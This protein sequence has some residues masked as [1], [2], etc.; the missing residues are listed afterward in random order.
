MLPIIHNLHY[1][2]QYNKQIV[3]KQFYSQL[4]FYI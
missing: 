3:L 4:A 2:N 1:V